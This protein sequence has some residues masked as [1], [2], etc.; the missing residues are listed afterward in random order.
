MLTLPESLHLVFAC[1]NLTY[2]VYIMTTYSQLSL[3]LYATL[4]INAGLA[5]DNTILALG[6]TLS[7]ESLEMLSKPRF[8]LHSFVPIL[9]ITVAEF[10]ERMQENSGLILSRASLFLSIVVSLAHLSKMLSGKGL[11][12]QRKA[13]HGVVHFTSPRLTAVDILPAVF[14]TLATLAA[15]AMLGSTPLASGALAMLI[16][17]GAFPPNRHPYGGLLSNLGECCLMAGF[18]AAEGSLRQL[19][20]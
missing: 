11:E 20:R 19:G 13:A 10:I 14:I 1:V 17:S 7:T 18:A 8:W 16:V 15:G 4:F 6:N 3:G 2:L 12:L 5:W 9:S